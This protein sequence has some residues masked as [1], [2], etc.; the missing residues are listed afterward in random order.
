MQAGVGLSDIGKFDLSVCTMISK[1]ILERA[2]ENPELLVRY[3]AS[4]RFTNFARYMNP[5]LDMTNF[6]KNYYEVLNRFAHGEIRKLIVSVPPQSGKALQIDTPVLTSTGWKRHGELEVGDYV[7]GEDGKPK[8]VQWVS[9]NYLWHTM[10]VDFADGFS[11]VA[12]HEHE[13]ELWCDRDSRGRNKNK[14]LRSKERLETQD[15]FSKRHR[16]H[17]YIMANAVIQM[18]KRE[19]PID[20][21]VLGLWLGDGYSRIGYICSGKEDVENLFQYGKV[22]KAEKGHRSDY[23]IC[24]IEGL[25]KSLRLAGLID[26]KHIPIEYLLSSEEQ[27]RELLCGLMDTDGYADKLGNC[28]FTQM[29]GQLADDVYVLLRSLGYKPCKHTYNAM[30]NGKMVGK[31]VRIGFSVNK[32]DKIFHLQR[33]QSRVDNKVKA[34]RDDKFKFFV[35][36]TSGNCLE[37][38]NCIQVEGGMYLAG[39][40]LVPTHNSQGSS[41]FLPAFLL[42]LN[43]DL[44]IVIGSYNAD[45][46]KSFNRDVQRI[47]NS[48]A[49]RAVFPDTFF[50]NGKLRMD[51]VYLCNSEVSEPVGHSGFVRAV[52]RNGAL[53][54]KSVDILILDDVYK[55]YNEANS[56]IIREQAFKWYSSVCR[57]R[58]HNDSQELIVFTRWH[59]DDLIG[60]IEAAGEPIIELA[61]FEQLRDIPFGSWVHINFPALKVGAPTEIDPREE[62]EALWEAK[63]SKKKLLATKAL[64]PNMFECLYQGNPSS[65]ESRLYGEFKTYVDRAEYGTL[66]RKGCCVDVADKGTDCLCSITYDV[67]RS[68]NTAYNEEKKRFEPILFLLVTDIILTEEGTDVTYVTVP[69]QINMQGSQVVW[70]ESNNGGE[71]FAKTIAKKVKASVKS[72]FNSSNKETRIITNASAV[73]QSVVFPYGWDT[74]YPKAYAHLSKF[75]RNFRSNLHDDLEDALTQAVERE[76]L[77]GNTKPYSQMRR[78][79]RRNN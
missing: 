39:F 44:K 18:P 60:R 2:Q 59:E 61:S 46:A 34:D 16:R 47:V 25:S 77:S 73:M 23:Y 22:R 24:H 14:P 58:L 64:D 55:D 40:E 50:N 45:Q 11:L 57:T 10:N 28:E 75:L 62:G 69:R 9:G 38:V 68:P 43:P 56:P 78:G 72:F 52:G 49:Y 21:Y 8:M 71:Q 15:I 65:A 26:N 63:H 54:G 41:R 31:K 79:I 51:N 76:I 12:A 4:K 3:M 66:I 53:T 27:R 19:L 32:G 36:N 6:H 20:P 74:T 48:E 7:F 5:Q 67:V 35:T 30:L 33:K 13:W 37:Q 1:D 29:E 42:G 17:P 70:V